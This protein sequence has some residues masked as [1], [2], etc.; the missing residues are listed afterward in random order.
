MVAAGAGL[1]LPLNQVMMVT[2]G[3]GGRFTAQAPDGSDVSLRLAVSCLVPP[4]A[5]DR[6][7]TAEALGE[8][9]I[10][11]ILERPGAEAQPL[12]IT[13]D[14]GIELV[15]PHISLRSGVVDIV[16]DALN[17]VGNAYNSLFRRSKRIIGAETVIAKSTTLHAGDRVSV[18]A[19][20]DV[21]QAGILS[22]TVE[23][24]LAVSSR[25][26]VI[27]AAADIRLNGERINVG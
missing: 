13:S 27:T 24:P 10:L 21:Q 14:V 3:A 26:A 7:L 4:S 25:T 11:A 9:F 6:V 5:G 15:A 23:G 18:I 12:R 17:M 2:G 20:A 19:Q 1:P 16:S 22:Q 8:T